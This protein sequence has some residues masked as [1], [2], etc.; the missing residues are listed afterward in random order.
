MK[1]IYIWIN[2]Y[3]FNLEE[4]Y[5]KLNNVG[6]S[7][8]RDIV[9][10]WT[11]FVTRWIHKFGFS[12]KGRYSKYLNTFCYKLYPQVLIQVS[13]MCFHKNILH[14]TGFQQ[15]YIQTLC[16]T[17]KKL[18]K[19]II[20]LYKVVIYFFLF[21]YMSDINF[22]TPRPICL[23]FWL[24]TRKSHGDILSLVWDSK[25]SWSTFIGKNS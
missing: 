17:Y 20:N 10:T 24:G 16:R 12:F 5:F 11:L 22:W 9:N 18:F 15:T 21:V 1:N 7:F 19:Q 3:R 8:R 14:Q 4:V 23:K 25:L 2:Q 13:E 6:F